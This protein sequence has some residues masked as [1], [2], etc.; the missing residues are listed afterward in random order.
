MPTRMTGSHGI[1]SL[2]GTRI[3]L[4]TIVATTTKN[5][6]DTA[7]PF[8]DTGDALMGKMLELQSDAAFYVR[9]GTV[10][11]ITVTAGTATTAGPLVEARER[12]VINMGGDKGWLACLS[13]SGTAT[14]QV[15]ELT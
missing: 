3:H 15:F 2:N 12:F 9:A 14:V 7:V 11:T 4:G 1:D 8:N 6:H 5:N 10:N 13:V